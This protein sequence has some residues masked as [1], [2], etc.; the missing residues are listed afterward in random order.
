MASRS[1]ITERTAAPNLRADAKFGSERT[2]EVR[3]IAESAIERDIEHPIPIQTQSTGRIP[4]P[5]TADI[6]VRGQPGDGL[7]HAQK[8][9]GAQ[10]RLPGQIRNCMTT[11]R[12]I[13]DSPHHTRH[14][15]LRAGWGFRVSSSGQLQRFARQLNRQRLP[16]RRHGDSRTGSCDKPRCCPQWRNP[17]RSESSPRAR[18]AFE[19]VRP[20]P[21]RHTPIAHAMLVPALEALPGITQH[22][23]SRR[24]YL[25]R[26][27]LAGA[28]T[29]AV[30]KRSLSYHGD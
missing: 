6:L 12:L 7:E 22:Q 15:R 1:G 21:E 14:T 9:P 13:I 18:Q 20:I 5:G 11:G 8:V 26:E 25:T 17:K 28:T 19:E 4:Q 23:R 30:L 10:A 27:S 3:N 29:T 24:H 2:I 16:V